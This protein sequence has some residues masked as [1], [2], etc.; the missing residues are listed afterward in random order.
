MVNREIVFLLVLTLFCSSAVLGLTYETGDDV[1]VNFSTTYNSKEVFVTS[2]SVVVG[3]INGSVD[4]VLIFNRSL[5]WDEVLAL[6]N[7]SMTYYNFT[8]LC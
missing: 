5:S 6:Y 2:S 7:A 4:E 3:N 1:Y 8:F